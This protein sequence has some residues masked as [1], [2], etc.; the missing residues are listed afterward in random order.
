MSLDEFRRWGYAVVDWVADYERRVA[1]LPLCAPVEP[2]QIRASL[3]AEPPQQ[4]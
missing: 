2:G 4:G 3:P 1:T